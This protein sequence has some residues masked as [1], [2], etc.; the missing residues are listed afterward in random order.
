MTYVSIE[1]PVAKKK[2]KKKKASYNKKERSIKSTIEKAL[3]KKLD[4]LYIAM[5][6]QNDLLKNISDR[7]SYS[8]ETF[9]NC[10]AQWMGFIYKC[11]IQVTKTY[12]ANEL[13]VEKLSE[14]T[15]KLSEETAHQTA[16]IKDLDR[17]HTVVWESSHETSNILH[18][19]NKE[20]K[21]PLWKK[22]LWFL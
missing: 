8:E 17:L 19:V 4:S 5:N 11:H 22:V 21:K 20:L 18:K 7:L 15:D 2:T 14:I 16:I 6:K 12:K 3:S 10:I 13:L 1:V 9:P